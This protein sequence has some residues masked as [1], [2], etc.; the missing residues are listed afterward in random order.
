MTKKFLEQDEKLLDAVVNE[1][2][3]KNGIEIQEMR[4]I[5]DRMRAKA[6]WI[7]NLPKNDD[8]L[9]LYSKELMD[10][11][12]IIGKS[13]VQQWCLAEESLAVIA[14]LEAEIKK[15]GLDV[16]AMKKRYVEINQQ[17]ES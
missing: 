10:F 13:Y 3:D 14:H 16:D 17:K 15:A 6:E 5:F 8:T 2:M 11:L 4:K 12:A 9:S 7:Y 1:R